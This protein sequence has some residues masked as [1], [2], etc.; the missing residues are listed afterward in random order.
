M[1]FGGEGGLRE[2]GLCGNHPLTQRYTNEV[3][4][5]IDVQYI[6]NLL[7]VFLDSE[8]AHITLSAFDSAGVKI[9]T[10][11]RKGFDEKFIF[12]AQL[13]V[14]NGL[15]SD[16][17]LRSESL[18]TFGISY[19]KSGGVGVFQGSCHHSLSY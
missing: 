8:K 11:D 13:L 19:N 1:S 18:N 7:S 14:E 2:L 17:E 15:V 4:M 12:H 10:D 6:S 5:R 3:T 16:K 9:Y